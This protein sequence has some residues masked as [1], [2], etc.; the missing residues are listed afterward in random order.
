MILNF[1]AKLD[2]FII[3]VKKKNSL[4][5][6]LLRKKSFKIIKE[7][8]KIITGIIDFDDLKFDFKN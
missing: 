4:F 7:Q 3:K 2:K 8:K 6:Q 5:Y 1:D